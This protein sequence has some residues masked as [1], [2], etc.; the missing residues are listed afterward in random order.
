MEHQQAMLREIE[1]L[2]T[3]LAKLRGLVMQSMIEAGGTASEIRG[4][5]CGEY[6]FNE[7]PEAQTHDV[8]LPDIEMREEPPSRPLP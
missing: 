7:P 4:A 3:G 8:C 1:T 2:E 6:T 5:P